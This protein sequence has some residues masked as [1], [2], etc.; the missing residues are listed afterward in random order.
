MVIRR[1]AAVLLVSAMLLCCLPCAFA[2]ATASGGRLPDGAHDA[3]FADVAPGTYYAEAVPW[4][5]ERGIT[6]G[7]TENKFRPN[8]IC[9]R[10]D[11]LAL[12]W[13]YDRC[14][15]YGRTP[16]FTDLSAD[17]SR[18][19]ALCWAADA[20]IAD[21]SED[22]RFRPDD[23]CTRAEAVLFLWRYAGSPS[24]T[25]A[26]RFRDVPAD[27][28]YRMAV[29]WALKRG[30]TRG[31]SK[32]TFSPDVPCTRAQLVTMLYRLNRMLPEKRLIVIDPGHQRHANYDKEPNGPGSS[33]L[34]AKTA[35][36]TYGE[37]SKL[38][39]YELNLTV[40]LQ[41]RE[42]LERRGYWVIM[43]R[44][45]HDVDL[46]N[47]ERAEIANRAGADIA[48]RIH[49]NG[50]SNTSVYGAETVTMTRNNPYHPELYS[51]C[52]ALSQAIIDHICL[53]TGA[54]NKGVWE[55]D[56]MTGVN[57][58]EVPVTIVE[59]GYMS[60][61]DEDRNLGTP[62]YQA[63]IVQGICDGVNEY[64]ANQ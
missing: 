43:T 11:V 46:S 22:E 33:E 4:A 35:S 6:D 39:E 8:R 63:K 57:W 30:V 23:C 29:L 20:G 52:R 28:A 40:S 54:K 42:A 47:I 21:D 55:T 15:H 44:E 5:V 17:D 34:K 10:A 2:D 12:L 62:S 31:T 38:N 18:Y 1:I 27:S 24:A 26:M 9:S 45:S 32:E 48:I 51:R 16:G 60:N 3:V 53:Q 56:T 64:F 14:P 19:S 58:S 61:P 49:A 37:I 7:V 13:Q 50:S 36:G 41:L 59:M 25:G